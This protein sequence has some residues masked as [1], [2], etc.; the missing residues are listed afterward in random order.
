MCQ[1]LL[2]FRG[3]WGDVVSEGKNRFQISICSGADFFFFFV[4]VVSVRNS[5]YDNSTVSIGLTVW[6]KN[7][8]QR[9]VTIPC[10]LYVYG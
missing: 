5:L 3:C 1:L 2:L 8:N 10:L 4:R 7:I 6:G 9:A